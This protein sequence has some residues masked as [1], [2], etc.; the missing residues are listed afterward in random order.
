M[1]SSP[2][3]GGFPRDRRTWVVTGLFLV[4]SILVYAVPWKEIPAEIVPLREFPRQLAKWQT[5]SEGLLDP[6]VLELLQPDDYLART[7]GSGGEEEPLSLFIGYFKS[8]RLG[9]H[10][11]SPRRCLPGSG[12]IPYSF[13][14]VVLPAAGGAPPIPV[15]EYVLEKGS[16]RILVLYWY[17]NSRRAVSREIWAKAYL[18]PDLLQYQRSDTTLVRVIQPS[19]SGWAA[20]A[21]FSRLVYS[22]LTQHF[23]PFPPDVP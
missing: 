3:K 6:E 11:H 23:Q 14:Q 2:S 20:A 1:S 21:D 22:A 17:Q 9:A 5:T 15:N 16:S 8:Q 7:Y 18:L 12:W 10:P 13:R 19:A 4:Q